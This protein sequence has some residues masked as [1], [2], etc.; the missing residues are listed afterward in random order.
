MDLV[1]GGVLLGGASLPLADVVVE[2]CGVDRG[3][4][5][6]EAEG[7]GAASVPDPTASSEAEGPRTSPVLAAP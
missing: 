7:V 3:G 1:D 6:C 2:A 5:S 4:G